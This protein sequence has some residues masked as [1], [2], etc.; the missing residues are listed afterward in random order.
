[1]STANQKSTHRCWPGYEPVP[2]KNEH[3]Q[4][5]CRPKS[6]DRLAPSEKQFRKKRDRQLQRWKKS[7]PGS[8]QKSAQHLHAPQTS[9]RKPRR[10]ASRERTS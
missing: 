8:P 2:G 4:G 9:S 7:H 3:S 1:M 5:S 6:K 10:K